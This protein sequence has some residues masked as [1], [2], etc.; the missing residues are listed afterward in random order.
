MKKARIF[1]LMLALVGFL[2]SFIIHLLVLSGRVP[3]SDCLN[4][5]LFLGAFVLFVSAAYLSGTR[6]VR[7]GLIAISEIVKDYPTWLTRTDA[8]FFA[9]LRLISVG[10]VL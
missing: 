8:F 5:V 10:D 4:M 9:Y 6:A 1:F 2:F 3:S 7:M